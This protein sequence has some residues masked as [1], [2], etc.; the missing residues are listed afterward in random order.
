V[1]A[2]VRGGIL[3]LLREKCLVQLD[4]VSSPAVM[5]MYCPFQWGMGMGTRHVLTGQSAAKS[6]HYLPYTLQSLESRASR[7]VPWGSIFLNS[8]AGNPWQN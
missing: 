2:D 3:E 7:H 5:I 6:K 1:R 8:W 4:V